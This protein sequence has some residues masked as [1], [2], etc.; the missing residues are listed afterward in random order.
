[1][2]IGGIIPAQKLKIAAQLL[3][4][5]SNK[6]GRITDIA[7]AAKAANATGQTRKNLAI[8]LYYICDFA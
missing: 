1:M 2:D 7:K 5:Q 6:N 3:R 8:P 4:M